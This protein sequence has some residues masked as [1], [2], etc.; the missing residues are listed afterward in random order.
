[1]NEEISAFGTVRTTCIDRV[2]SELKGAALAV[3]DVLHVVMCCGCA[4]LCCVVLC[5]AVQAGSSMRQIQGPA[6]G[7]GGGCGAAFEQDDSVI[8]KGPGGTTTGR[9]VMGSESKTAEEQLRLDNQRLQV[10]T[11]L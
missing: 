2:K 7:Q 5:C 6:M 9:N 8:G 3:C 11:T 4:V 1:M 10:G